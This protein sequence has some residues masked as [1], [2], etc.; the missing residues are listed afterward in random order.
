MKNRILNYCAISACMLSLMKVDAQQIEQFTLVRENAA[1]LNPAMVGAKGFLAGTATFRRQYININQSP[2]TAFVQ[3]EGQVEDKNVGIGASFIHDNTGPVGKT[4]VTL[5]AAY[6][7]RFNKYELLQEENVHY[8]TEDRHMLCVGLSFSLMQYRLNATLL[9]PEMQGD[10]ELY[11]SHAYKL[12]PDMSLGVWYQW[13][14]KFYAGIS[15]PQIIGLKVN[16]IG[17]DGTSGIKL[18]QHLNFMLGGKIN[19]KPEKFSIDP[20]AALRWENNAPPQGDIG[21][22]FTF[23]DAIWIGANYRSLN[24]VIFDL[25]LELK[26]VV[27][28]CYAY[29]LELSKYRNDIGGTH[30]ACVQ[31]RFNR[32]GLSDRKWL[33]GGYK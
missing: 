16:Y 21:L 30:E 31:F 7:I 17:K 13:G 23:L 15:V 32:Q 8:N 5:S 14:R 11:T 22:R 26:G 4:G 20:V 18:V 28:L 19:I 3:M 27:R 10:P 2:Y 12:L 25:G 24:A 6:Q 1:A 29:D 9:H 33:G